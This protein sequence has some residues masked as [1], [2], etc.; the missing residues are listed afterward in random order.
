MDLETTVNRSHDDAVR[1]TRLPQE[2][3]TARRIDLINRV[4]KSD[5]AFY[6]QHQKQ[7]DTLEHRLL[8]KLAMLQ[9]LNADVSAARD[10][11]PARPRHQIHH[12]S[13]RRNRTAQDL[14]YAET[15]SCVAPQARLGTTFRTAHAD[16]DHAP[17]QAEP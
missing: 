2:L 14:P 1:L 13:A 15:D 11:Q 3:Q 5:S 17:R 16:A 6:A 9:A 4:W 10:T 8:L 12:P 7:V